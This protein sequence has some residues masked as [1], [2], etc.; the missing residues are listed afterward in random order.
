MKTGEGMKKLTLISTL[1]LALMSTQSFANDNTP[2]LD[3]RQVNQK[4]RIAQGVK[5]GELTAKETARLIKGQK[6]LQRMENRA[7]ADGV[8][9]AKERAKLQHK[10]NKE[11]KK[12]FHNKHDQQK[13]P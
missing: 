9:T 13:R 6:Q 5:S 12:I 1:A 8:V 11:S 4:V 2:V 3:K 7:K 10:A